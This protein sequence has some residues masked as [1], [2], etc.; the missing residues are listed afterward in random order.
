MKRT[1]PPK[2]R[3]PMKGTT[4]TPR[5]RRTTLAQRDERFR[6][7]FGSAARVLFVQRLPCV[8]CGDSPC[9]NHHDPTKASGGSHLDISPLCYRCHARRHNVGVRSFWAE[10]GMTASEANAATEARWQDV[11]DDGW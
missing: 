9:E 1:G 5:G 8:R 11:G 7:Q 3:T 6:Q 4:S 10:V 2:R